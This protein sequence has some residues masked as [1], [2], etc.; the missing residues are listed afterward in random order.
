MPSVPMELVMLHADFALC[1]VLLA[2]GNCY[3]HDTVI[4]KYTVCTKRHINFQR[5]DGKVVFQ[6]STG[7][8]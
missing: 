5:T 1:E 6:V 3:L 8:H 4:V 2:A 7:C